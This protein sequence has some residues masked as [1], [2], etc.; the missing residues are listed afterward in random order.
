MAINLNATSNIKPLRPTVNTEEQQL[1]NAR[2]LQTA[3]Q[4]FVGKSFYG[5]MMKSMRST[6]GE[7]AYFH[8]GNA[9]KVFQTQLDHEIADEMSTSNSGELSAAMFRRQF[10]REAKLIANSEKQA[11]ASLTDLS[12]LRR[13]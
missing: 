2:D 8:G 11:A 7:P 5:E 9:E 3:F 12:S 10:P 4:D 6:Q 1:S 13:R